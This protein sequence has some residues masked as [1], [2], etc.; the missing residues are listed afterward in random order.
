MCVDSVSENASLIL[1]SFLIKYSITAVYLK[2]LN[3]Q[4]SHSRR[5]NGGPIE[6]V[7]TSLITA[8]QSAKFYPSSV[9]APVETDITL[10]LNSRSFDD[11]TDLENAEFLYVL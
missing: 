5:L 8:A 7:D 4:H 11:L 9:N 3:N 6:V 10:K 1:Y 2:F